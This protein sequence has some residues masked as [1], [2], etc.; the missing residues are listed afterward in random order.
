[1]KLDTEKKK[2]FK[3][4]GVIAGILFAAWLVLYYTSSY[5]ASLEE[6]LSSE[7]RKYNE[8]KAKAD[9][10]RI[11]H[12]NLVVSSEEYR[13]IN[14]NRLPTEDGF[15]STSSRIR[16]VRPIIEE[17]KKLYRFPVLD[18]TFSNISDKS[19]EFGAKTV[20][21]LENEISIKFEG[22]SDELVFSFVEDFI[23]ALPGYLNIKDFNIKRKSNLTP[24][25]LT[26]L[27]NSKE[28]KPLVEGTIVFV[29]DTLKDENAKANDE[30][31]L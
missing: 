7:T 26:L 9:S 2:L 18:V 28:I 16:A 11:E 31:K 10:L 30:A 14:K 6:N 1:M 27:K 25:I 8:I 21:V 23:K 19:K 29:W 22:M 13:N 17:M 20:V 3:E 4:I 15:S 24:E 12:K 5:E